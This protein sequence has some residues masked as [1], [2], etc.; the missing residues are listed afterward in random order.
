VV[1]VS[2]VVLV[3]GQPLPFSKLEFIPELANFGAEMNSTAITD[4]QGRFTLV[5]AATQQPGA[6]VAK[7]HVLVTEAPTP[8]EFRSQDPQ[9]QARYAQYMAKLKNRPIPDGYGKLAGAPE[10]EVKADQTD[11][12]IELTRR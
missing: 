9:V 12:K 11:Y 1:A 7:H 2:G 8:G 4:E 6:V 5:L 10:V 3:N